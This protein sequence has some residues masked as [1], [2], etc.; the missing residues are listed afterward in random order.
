MEASTEIKRPAL[1]Y[2]GGKWKLAPWIISHFPEH[3]NYVE[4]CGGAA[5]VLLQKPRSPLETY[6]DL[7]GNVVNFFRILRDRPDELIR[8]IRL[9]PWARAEYELSRVPAPDDL[10]RARRF[11]VMCWQ[12]IGGQPSGWRKCIDHNQ[13]GSRHQLSW[14]MVD[15]ITEL[16]NVANRFIHVQI[17]N[18]IAFNVVE[19]YDN[20]DAL[21]YFDPPYLQETRTNGQQYLQETDEMFHIQSASYLRLTQGYVIVSG[22]ACPLYTELYEQHG[23]IRKD[24]EVQTNSGGKRIE[25]IWLSPR[26]WEALTRDQKQWKRLKVN[27]N[28]KVDDLPLWASNP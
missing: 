6:N 5:S 13:R 8:K 16:E 4:P 2:Y 14:Y 1:R 22:Y 26:T 21:I 3:K 9:T 25:S 28:S 12:A 11:F 18:D 10:E 17:E 23:W 24:K 19:R 20:P 15:N 27:G 7:D